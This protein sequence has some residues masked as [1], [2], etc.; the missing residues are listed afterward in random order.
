MDG[1]LKER[2]RERRREREG[3]GGA[4]NVLKCFGSVSKR[5]LRRKGTVAKIKIIAKLLTLIIRANVCRN[6]NI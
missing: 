3:G 1:R 2:D 4:E 5:S 6:G